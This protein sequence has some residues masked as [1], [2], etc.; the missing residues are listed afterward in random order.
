MFLFFSFFKV[1]LICAAIALVSG[2]ILLVLMDLSLMRFH[3]SE[4]G[5]PAFSEINEKDRSRA[6][7]PGANL[8]ANRVYTVKVN[9]MFG[10]I[11]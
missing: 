4:L 7:A 11:I 6:S 9:W 10:I 2:F 8:T 3:H 5:N 1:A